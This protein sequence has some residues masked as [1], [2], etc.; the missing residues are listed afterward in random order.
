M[1]LKQLTTERTKSAVT[2]S[3]IMGLMLFLAFVIH[4][5]FVLGTT[6]I[7][8]KT[9][10]ANSRNLNITLVSSSTDKKNKN[11]DYVA[12]ETQLGAGNTKEKV[13]VTNS[14]NVKAENSSKGAST[15]N[16]LESSKQKQQQGKSN[17]ITM[18]EKSDLTIAQA[19]D[20]TKVQD[21]D[22]VSKTEFIRSHKDVN[23]IKNE[24]SRIQLITNKRNLTSR[25]VS[26]STTKHNDAAYIKIWN[27]KIRRLGNVNLSNLKK[28]GKR[29]IHLKV[30]LTKSGVVYSISVTSSTGSRVFNERVK[31]LIRQGSPYKPVPQNVLGN[32]D[33]YVIHNR[34]VIDR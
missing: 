19:K 30:S 27:D 6:F 20:Q 26:A 10:K 14:F 2:T 32:K 9:Q 18:K 8:V 22:N 7:S 16:K 25:I 28:A 23:I 15:Q 13:Q 21:K 34:Y 5:I 4:L 24:L 31:R 29:V 12:N 11:A 1:A 3:D 33:L 17:I